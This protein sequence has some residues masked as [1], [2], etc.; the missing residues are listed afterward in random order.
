MSIDK[1]L[2]K[3]HFYGKIMQKM[4]TKKL[5]PEP[6]FIWVNNPKQPL[7]ARNYFK[8]KIFLKG[9]IK[10]F[11]KVNFKFMQANSWHHKLF[12]FHLFFWIWKVWKGS[13]YH[14]NLNI[15]RT[16]SFLDEIKKKNSVFDGLPF[17]E[18]NKN[19][20]KNSGHKL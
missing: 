7:H 20:R 6:F 9:I 16:K 2:N 14:K 11:K 4:F 8:N 19:F 1:V 5:I 15:S 18:K 10:T 17:G 12:H 3:E 13:G